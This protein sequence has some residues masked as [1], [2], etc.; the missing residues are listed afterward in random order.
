MQCADVSILHGLVCT[1][2]YNYAMSRLLRVLCNMCR[3]IVDCPYTDLF[4]DPIVHI[5]YREGLVK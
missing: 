2:V 5:N 4:F 1:H 3:Y